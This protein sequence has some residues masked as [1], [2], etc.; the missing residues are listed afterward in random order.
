MAGSVTEADI[1][2]I[3]RSLLQS[4][5]QSKPALYRGVSGQILDRC[6]NDAPLR[7]ALF[8]FIDVLPQL[9]GSAAQA[10]HL[11]A[12]LEESG[13]SG[14]L[15]GLMKLAARPSLS[16][17]AT[18]Q[19][20]HMAQ[21]FLV[22]ESPHAITAVLKALAAVPAALTLDAVGEAVLTDSEADAY[23]DRVLWQLAQDW[24]GQ[25]PHLSIKLTALATGFDPLDAAG[26]KKRV[27]S[28]LAPIIEAACLRKATLTVDMEHHELK[29]QIVALFLDM[30]ADFKDTR[31]QPAIA[32][33]AYLPETGDD[34]RR[35]LNSAQRSGRKIG[36][37]L[38]KGAYWDQ[39][40]AWSQERGWPMPCFRDKASTDAHYEKLTAELLART[41]VLLPAIAGHNPRSLAVA[42]AHARHHG[43]RAG[44]W[45]VQ[46]LHGM[47]EPLRDALAQ[48]EV[49]LRIYVPTGDLL[50]G[51]AYLIRRLLEN[52]AG[53][54][55]LRQTWLDASS[56]E[57]LLKAPAVPAPQASDRSLPATLPLSDFSRSD[58]CNEFAKALSATS[59]ALHS[60]DSKDA[61]GFHLS[62][63]P[64]QPT[65]VLGRTRMTPVSEI[66]TA[67]ASARKAQQ[68][69]QKKGTAV[70][71]QHLLALAD[72]IEAERHRFAALQVLEA[73][74]PWREADADVA[75][76]IDFLHYYSTQMLYLAG[77]HT[78]TNFPGEHNHYRYRARGIAVVIAP[79][80]F[81][82][83]IL[84]GMTA[85]ALVTGNAVLM[86]PA[87]PGLQSALAL[88]AAMDK[89]GIPAALCPLLVGGV[90]LGQALVAH[91]QVDVIAFTGS[92]AV[93]L[94]ILRSA[95][96]PQP[97]QSHVKQVVCEMGGKNAIIVDTDA[98]LDE[99]VAGILAS[100]F[101]YSGQKCSACSRVIAVE[102]IAAQLQ[103][104]LVAAA[105][106]LRWGN[107]A[108]PGFD[109]G[110]LINEA[111]QQKALTYIAAGK[112]EARLLWQG[113]VPERNNTHQGWY[114]PPTIF[115]D[116]KPEHRIAREEIFA[117]VLALMTAPDFVTAL[118]MA[119][120]S[121]YALTGGIY[122]RL[123]QHLELAQRD[124]RVGNLYLN[125]RITGARVGVQP[126][127]GIALSGTGI[128]AGGPDYLKQFMWMQS[129][130]QNV[131]RKGFVPEG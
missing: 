111:A 52:T 14:L 38:V 78:T 43:L 15:P 75:E 124:Y 118:A 121:D 83:A 67:V 61:P 108:D 22:E 41:D 42:I 21:N 109:H 79:W 72:Q 113:M 65:W 130:S 103:E 63:N 88:R 66:N 23:R 59:G 94:D 126:F 27:Y 110:P 92:R 85:A 69:W 13:S 6:L 19:V 25:V 57:A 16:W 54:S 36:I 89:V 86:K 125:R 73:G 2:A 107:P 122:S 31:W 49:P 45:E 20:R 90:E 129:V 76:A 119:N 123:P 99:A 3:G 55:I 106:T 127:G 8:R 62:R 77:V 50:A 93:G 28:R 87:L 33:Q 91:P 104:R 60:N 68:E 101:G 46:M 34:I 98:D 12:Y 81:P 112:T 74:K 11:A 32:L 128:Q 115:A 35:M 117:P 105:Q 84:T 4:A 26:T 30:V 114:C 40:Q 71:V 64:H 7:A 47:A 116:V 51:M 70:R 48:Q 56:D 80:N 95:H 37:R 5:R 102:D 120:D 96:T 82:L 97:G 53:T 1:L 18:L 29:G 24:Q 58:V 39:E 44:Q 9:K 131:M 10:G 17:L 100:A